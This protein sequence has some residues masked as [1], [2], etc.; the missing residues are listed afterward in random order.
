[1]QSKDQEQIKW[2]QERE[3]IRAEVHAELQQQANTFVQE[4]I[5]LA[6]TQM[7]AEIERRVAEHS[8]HPQLQSQLEE[9]EFSQ[10]QNRSQMRQS[11]ASDRSVDLNNDMFAPLKEITEKMRQSTI[12]K[13][14]INPIVMSNGEILSGL[15]G[16]A[17]DNEMEF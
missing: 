3:R 11:Q 6:H 7:Y 17:T 16:N 13:S 14:R 4:Q 9:M 1:M 12:S 10:S 5:Q 2:M 8:G 15:I